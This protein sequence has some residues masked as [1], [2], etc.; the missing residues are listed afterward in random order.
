M[1]IFK[2]K[3]RKTKDTRYLNLML[4]RCFFSPFSLLA[5]CLAV[6][7]SKA[8]TRS[9]MALSRIPA[10]VRRSHGCF[11][12]KAPVMTLCFFF[13]SSNFFSLSRFVFSCSSDNSVLFFFFFFSTPVTTLCLKSFRHIGKFFFLMFSRPL[14]NV[15]R[16]ARIHVSTTCYHFNRKEIIYVFFLFFFSILHQS[17]LTF[18]CPFV[19]L[20][21]IFLT[22]VSARLSF[23]LPPFISRSRAR[24]FGGFK[25]SWEIIVSEGRSMRHR[26]GVPVLPET[27]V[28]LLT[29]NHESGRP[30]LLEPSAPRSIGNGHSQ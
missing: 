8:F 27:S 30:S 4:N 12:R 25:L 7:E 18:F 29:E 24:F 5:T 6:F 21:L 9:L 28:F 26:H 3:K 19:S 10:G 22:L 14:L 23:L 11:S 17:S 15:N 20:S 2:K 1:I 16:A 13:R